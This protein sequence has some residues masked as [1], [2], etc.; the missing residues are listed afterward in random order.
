[1]EHWELPD[2]LR[3]GR[4][5][6]RGVAATLRANRSCGKIWLIRHLCEAFDFEI[7]LATARTVV[8]ALD[9]HDDPHVD[10]LLEGRVAGPGRT[11]GPND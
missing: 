8:E 1:M 3:E 2:L 10:K 4:R 11:T 5:S 7:D 6:G 9:D